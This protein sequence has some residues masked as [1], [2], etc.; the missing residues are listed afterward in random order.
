MISRTVSEFEHYDPRLDTLAIECEECSQ[1]ATR[2]EEHFDCGVQS[3]FQ[4]E[5]CGWTESV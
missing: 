4:C 2:V 1:I 3:G 5:N